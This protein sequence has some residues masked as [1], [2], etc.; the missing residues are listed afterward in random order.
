M[1]SASLVPKNGAIAL[2]TYVAD[3]NAF[4]IRAAQSIEGVTPFGAA[5]NA[6][7]VAAG[8]VDI[9]WS[10]SAAALAHATGTKPGIDNSGAA[11]FAPTGLASTLFT[12]DT[13]VTLGM[14]AVV[15]DWSI[16]VAR[17][18]AA[19]PI[20]IS[21]KNYGDCTETWAVS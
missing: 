1:A 15:G 7:N 12:L 2:G 16:G 4:T 5:V 11:I 6:K 20:S 14:T 9:A 17:M 21:G 3:Y 8:T 10:I 18:R 19:V 13:G